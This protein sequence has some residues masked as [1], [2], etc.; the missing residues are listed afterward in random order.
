MKSMLLAAIICFIANM[1]LAQGSKLLMFEQDGCY[2]CEIW[3]DEISE[4]YPK[5]LEGSVAPLQRI[6]IHST[7]S[8][9][10]TLK[11]SP[12]FTPTFIIVNNN[13]EV[14][15]IEGYPGEDFFWGLIDKILLE[16]PEYS[17]KKGV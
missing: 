14:G 8:T 10:I 5:T 7:L 11:S 3:D 6:D 2:W 13:I 16:I 12:Q 4:I 15:R 9:E 1:T 17:L